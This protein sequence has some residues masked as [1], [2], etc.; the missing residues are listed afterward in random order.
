MDPALVADKFLERPRME[1]RFFGFRFD[2]LNADG[3]SLD[4]KTLNKVFTTLETIQGMD[5]KTE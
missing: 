5:L 2:D 4:L 3:L 1:Q